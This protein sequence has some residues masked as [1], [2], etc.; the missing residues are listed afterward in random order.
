MS[1][2]KVIVITSD[3]VVSEREIE[4]LAAMQAIV[5]GLIE[6]VDLSDGSTMFVNEE[7]AYMPNLRFNSIASDVA[8]LG[9]RGDLMIR[10][11]AGNVFIAGPPDD[12]GNTTDV[13]D[14]ARRWVRRVA[15]EA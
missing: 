6:P 7:F 9:G 8:G 15:R 10:G 12:D 5:E 4:G 3:K 14:K 13:T 1:A 2:I 11:I